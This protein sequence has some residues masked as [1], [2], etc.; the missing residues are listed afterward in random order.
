MTANRTGSLVYGFILQHSA[1]LNAI[2]VWNKT[3][4]MFLQRNMEMEDIAECQKSISISQGLVNV[5]I[6]VPKFTA[7]TGNHG[8]LHLV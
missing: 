3:V 2:T 8:L 6:A 5:Q 1:V 4:L 7:P